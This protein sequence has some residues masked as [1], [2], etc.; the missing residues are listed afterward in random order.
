MVWSVTRRA[1][2]WLP[3]LAAIA[4]ATIGAVGHSASPQR[5]NI[6]IIVADDLGFSDIGAF[7]GEISTPNLD[8]LAARG[9]RMTGFHTA[10]T[11]SPTRAM[12][13]TG[14]DN[15]ETGLGTMA[16]MMLT[17]PPGT[18]RPY[19]GYLNRRAATLAER[20][21][22][23]GYSTMMA[24]KWHMGLTEDQ[25]PKARGFDHSYALLQGGHD[26]FG[27]DQAQAWKDIGQAATYREDGVLATY[28]VGR[29]SADVFTERML[30]YLKG[31]KAQKKPFFAYLTYTQP[32]WPMQAPAAAI[33]KYKGRYD[34]GYEVLRAQRLERLKTLGL[35]A[36]DVRPAP[37][38]GVQPWASLSPTEKAVAA[39]KM[40]IYAAMVDVL[41][42]SVGRVLA[43]LKADG[44][45]DNT[46][47]IFVSDNGP[48][49]S[50]LEAPFGLTAAGGQKK[51]GLN[52]SL[53]RLGGRGT[54]V[55]YG[56]GWAQAAS[57]PSLGV[58]GRPN[59][60]GIRATAIVAG[61]GVRAGLVQ[62]GLLHVMDI[63]PTALS[64]A[65]VSPDGTPSSLPIRGKSWSSMLGGGAPIRDA[66]DTIGWE[67]VGARAFREGDWKA[68]FIPT[69]H[70]ALA[71]A[72]AEAG[73]VAWKLYNLKD[74]PGETEDLAERDPERLKR[75]IAAWRAYAAETGVV[76]P[77]G[78][79]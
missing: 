55:T 48:E 57:A 32:H 54:Y 69:G 22:D 50:V 15:H 28:P 40:E 4:A 58:K 53:E 60:G 21:K 13:L 33:A 34:Q 51:L 27:D 73:P 30:A 59:E 23:A 42:Q 9:Q 75:M 46:L 35:I 14:A 70:I 36:A 5:P 52:N 18:P 77:P 71:N 11:C 62:D 6:L 64:A 29:Y 41:D 17:L 72:N 39:R 3:A 20:L 37:M 66:E 78:A 7:G 26:H 47:I 49:G 67:F 2:V 45:L 61:P 68:T 25:S 31:A 16:E 19:E 12:L 24:G 56:P 74:D 1:K 76:I 38:T 10:P 79:P 8:A 65:G 44:Q 43:Q 63:L